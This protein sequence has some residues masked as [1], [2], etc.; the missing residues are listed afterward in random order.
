MMDNIREIIYLKL[1]MIIPK[2]MPYLVGYVSEVRGEFRGLVCEILVVRVRV[3]YN[4]MVVGNKLV[5][6]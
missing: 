5:Y 3:L 6:K 1:E 2:D 4:L